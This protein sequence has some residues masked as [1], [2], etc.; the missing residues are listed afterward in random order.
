MSDEFENNFEKILYIS[1]IN[2]AERTLNSEEM[3]PRFKEKPIEQR[4]AIKRKI[5]NELKKTVKQIGMELT[6][7]NINDPQNLLNSQDE[8]KKIIESVIRQEYVN[9]KD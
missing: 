9:T 5:L 8:V 1:L 6:K 4:I 7:K 2:Y 3:A